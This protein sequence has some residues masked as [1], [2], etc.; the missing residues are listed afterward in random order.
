MFP[1]VSKLFFL[2]VFLEHIYCEFNMLLIMVFVL[3]YYI[4]YSH[5]TY[6][7]LQTI[8]TNTY[9]LFFLFVFFGTYLW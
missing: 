5:H 8:L 6:K 2:F 4:I 7:Y 3:I 9:K 1:N